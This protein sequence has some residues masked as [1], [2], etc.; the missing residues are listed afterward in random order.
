MRKWSNT[1]NNH[2]TSHWVKQENRKMKRGEY[3]QRLRQLHTHTHTRAR[4]HA[5]THTHTHRRL[6]ALFPA[7]PG[8]AGTRKVKP[9]GIL[10]KQETVSGNGI[11]WA[12]CNSAPCSRQITVPAPH[13]SVFYRPDALLAAQ[14]TASEHWRHKIRQL[15]TSK[16]DYLFFVTG[17]ASSSPSAVN[18]QWA[19]NRNMIHKTKLKTSEF[20]SAH[21][22]LPPKHH[23]GCFRCLRLLQSSPMC[24]THTDTQ[25]TSYVGY[26]LN[27]KYT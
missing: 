24:P 7:L 23:L 6:T 16:Q 17:G 3:V 4:T 19:F 20:A 12:I 18:R 9:I 21:L 11:S 13:H 25:I 1:Q 22:S 10:V 27:S 15:S 5:H 8:W 26:Y 14:P 2:Q